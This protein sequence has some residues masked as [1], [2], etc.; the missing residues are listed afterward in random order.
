MGKLLRVQEV[1]KRIG[2]AIGTTQNLMI[3]P[4]FPPPRQYGPHGIKLYATE[5]VDFWA[6]HRKNARRGGRKRKR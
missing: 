3:D 1:A 6:K 2:L 4:E 5:D